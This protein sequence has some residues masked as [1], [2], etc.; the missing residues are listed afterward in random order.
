MAT[1]WYISKYVGTPHGFTAG[2]RAFWLLKEMAQ[3]EHQCLIIT[4]DSNK[5]A[6]VPVLS[7][8]FYD[9]T[10]DNVRIRWLKTLKYKKA[11]SLRRILSWLDFEKNL[12]FMPK[13]N[14]IQPQYIIVSS[15]SLLTILNGIL[16][17]KKY[18]CKLIFEVRDIWPL[19]LTSEGGY[20]EKN[21]F[22]RVLSLIEKI[23]YMYADQIVGTMP[24]L[25]SH[26]QNRLGYDRKVFCIPIGI[27]ANDLPTA[28]L[29]SLEYKQSLSNHAD[30]F[31]VG[32]VGSIGI[33]NALEPLL[34]AAKL[35]ENNSTIQFLIVGNGDLKNRLVKNYGHLK[36]VIFLPK[37]KHHE[38][39]LILKNCNILYFSTFNSEIWE[40]GQSLN[41]IIDYMLAGKPIIGSYS[42]F[43]SMINEAKCGSFVPAE[44]EEMLKNKITEYASKD[45]AELERM[46][47]S[48]RKWLI[49]N[50]TYEKLALKYLNEILLNK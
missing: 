26:V 38:V 4:S 35:L 2:S 43:P 19:T 1:I 22:V 41:K 30:K 36:N 18:K 8:R 25:K 3:K 48:G 40:F 32:Y 31:I 14:L 21:L 17:R 11:K 50:R 10:I 15:L 34:K 37:V 23:G 24:N 5:L 28:P 12:F 13:D 6:S 20:S 44:D 9:E 27:P 16:L 39:P 42:G 46:G 33:S 7:S 29:K 47:I 45:L 49:E